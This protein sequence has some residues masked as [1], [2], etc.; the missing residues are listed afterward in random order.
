MMRSLYNE[1]ALCNVPAGA[2]VWANMGGIVFGANLKI[3]EN[4]GKKSRA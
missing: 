3:L 4:F 1:R 2:A